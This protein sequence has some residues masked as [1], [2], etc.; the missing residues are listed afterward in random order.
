MTRFKNL[1]ILLAFPALTSC[2]KNEPAGYP[3]DS[4]LFPLKTG[5]IWVYVDSF[6]TDA[7]E[8][9]GFDTFALKTGQPLSRNGQIYIPVNDQYDDSIF[10]VRSDD[11]SAFILEPPGESLLF[12]TP[13]DTFRSATILNYDGGRMQTVIFSKSLSNTSFPSYRIVITMD[14]GNW[15]DFEQRVLFFSPHIGIIQ[16]SDAWKNASGE[17]YTSDTYHLTAFTLN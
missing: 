4:Q 10:I 7:G 13:V 8:Y 17:I 1:W 14:D 2:L 6:Y 3:F 15:H 5:N 11:S 9:Y 12:S 16:G